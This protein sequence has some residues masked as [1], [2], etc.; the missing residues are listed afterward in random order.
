[1]VDNEN[2]VIKDANIV[3]MID[4]QDQFKLKPQ[5]VTSILQYKRSSMVIA[6]LSNGYLSVID[7]SKLKAIH[8]TR[9]H[10][11]TFVEMIS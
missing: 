10:K 9:V 8:C 1:M 6:T 3:G 5:K 11:G 7:I 4:L 2:G